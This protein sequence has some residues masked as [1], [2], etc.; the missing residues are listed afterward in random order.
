[1]TQADHIREYVHR[2]F[3]EP[4]RKQGKATITVRAGDV[5]QAMGLK[6]RMPAICS[7]LQA[8]KFEELAGVRLV[9]RE[10]PLQGANAR[11]T[12]DLE[13]RDSRVFVVEDKYRG[14]KEYYL[15]Y[16][17]LI[18]AAQYGGTTTYQAIAQ[19]MGL[20]VTGAH[21]GMETGRVL[22]E[23]SEDELNKGRPMLSAIAVGV[24]GLPGQGFFGLAEQLGRLPAGASEEE[25]RDFWEQERDAVYE[26]WRRE[27]K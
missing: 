21:M 23:I 10:G 15:V 27:F 9:K 25:K 26:A 14:S 7:A 24:S 19:V 22:G 3:V 16:S 17:E 4:A 8:S 20:P 13:R 5:H 11:F 12:F 18:K 2:S 6:N 1:M